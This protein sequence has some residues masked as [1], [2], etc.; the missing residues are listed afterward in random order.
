M[1]LNKLLFIVSPPLSP[2]KMKTLFLTSLALL[3][4]MAHL[5]AQKTKTKAKNFHYTDYFERNLGESPTKIERVANL[6]Y[7]H[8]SNQILADSLNHPAYLAQEVII[9]PIWQEKRKGEYWLYGGWFAPKQ[10]EKALTQNIFELKPLGKDSFLIRL[11]QLKDMPNLEW[12]KPNPF[13]DKSSK[14]LIFMEN[15]EWLGIWKDGEFISKST[16]VCSIDLGEQIQGIKM[17]NIYNKNGFVNLS[18]FYN[19]QGLVVFSYEDKPNQF[20]RL[21]KETLLGKTKKKK[22]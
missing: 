3:L 21:K 5:Q 2:S 6:M 4:S 16:Q 18:N 14:D 13:E 15:C 22:R 20:D 7:G 11:H 1:D 9:L 8:Y 19:A 12:Q 10:Y 17:H